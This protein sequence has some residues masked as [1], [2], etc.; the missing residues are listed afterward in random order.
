MSGEALEST[1]LAEERRLRALRGL[2]IL[3]TGPDPTLDLLTRMASQVARVPISLVSLVDAERQWF[4]ARCGLHMAQ[5]DRS[6]AFCDLVVRT[7]TELI[8]KD[9][10]EDERFRDNP[11]VTDDP[12]IRFYVGLP[13]REPGGT[14][15]GTLC[16]MDRSP[17]TI[18]E[19]QL[20]QLRDLATIAMQQILALRQALELER[21]S[22]QIQLTNMTLQVIQEA[23]NKLLSDGL[24][25]LW[26][27]TVLGQLL[28]LTESEYGFIGKVSEDAEGPFLKTEAIT[29][30][31]WN[32]ETRRFYEENSPA[33][34]VFR[35]MDTLFGRPI[36]EKAVL[37]SND[38]ATDQR[39]GGRPDGHPPLNTFAGLPVWGRG[40]EMIGLVG[41]ANREVGYSED[42]V[43]SLS[44][45][46]TLIS[47]VLE[48]DEVEARRAE[49]VEDL[50]TSNDFLERVLTVSAS[51]F[52]A[53][54]SS[55]G[56]RF[57]NAKAR[58]LFNDLPSDEAS[59]ASLEEGLNRLFPHAD[60]RSWLMDVWSRGEGDPEFRGVSVLDASLK[61][62][63][64]E[65]SATALSGSDGDA[66]MLMLAAQD[67]TE[68]DLL[69]LSKVENAGLEARIEQLRRQQQINEV[70]FECVDLLQHSEA[71]S[72]GLGIVSGAAAR[73]FESANV[74]LFALQEE[75]DSFVEEYKTLRWKSESVEDVSET[76]DDSCWA[77]RSRRVHGW[78]DGGHQVKCA[79][80]DGADSPSTWCIPLF[81][82]DKLIGVLQLASSPEDM[83]ELGS[84]QFENSRS[85]ITAVAQTLSSALS[86]ILL[87]ESLHQMATTDPLTGVW[88]R[89]AFEESA[90]KAMARHHR[91]GE[92]MA[93][94]VLDIDHFKQVNDDLGH[95]VGDEALKKVAQAI[96]SSIRLGDFAGRVGGEEFALF[97]SDVGDD[98]HGASMALERVLNAVR[99]EC[100]VEGRDI[101]AS[102][103]FAVASRGETYG[104][105]YR[106]ADQA[107]YLAKRNG[108]DR[109]Q[110]SEAEA[111]V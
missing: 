97:L 6:V 32:E 14:V 49:V 101:T 74:R 88:N 51:G 67:Q 111:E 92:P 5:T 12:Y 85:Q 81:S 72:E 70:L 110:R 37:I 10:R 52:V 69:Q 25:R 87:R 42:L 93:L 62:R 7:E 34:L 78:W 53:I 16:V 28:A 17:R 83:A 39:A 76:L 11:L 84:D 48:T 46:L 82:L 8:V 31:A 104:D 107:L 18:S 64:L 13:L 41:L 55:G 91:K 9:A 58:Q 15:I 54:D 20:G 60:D 103:G 106:R 45:A 99:G 94:A 95:D 108:R 21:N 40:N 90:R 66:E 47:A 29:N 73:L 86:T 26:W 109:I 89:R 44:P 98:G 36:V 71:I 63:R 35:N 43:G 80:F 38:V 105:L 33:G 50:R 100:R 23:Q 4:K 56:L 2:E 1:S 77:V 75:E 27:D 19:E 59:F 96:D 22:E 102:I 79:H 57:A 61:S 30:I 3:D 24:D 68:R 65:L